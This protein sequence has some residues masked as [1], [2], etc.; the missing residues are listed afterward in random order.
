MNPMSFTEKPAQAIA[1]TS[2]KGGVGKSSTAI[3]LAIALAQSNKRVVLFDGDIGLA[4][5]D[6]LLG[7]RAKRDIS[8]VLA[9]RCSMDE[10]ILN[11]PS[12]IRIVPGG[13]GLSDLADASDAERRSL[14][15][16]ISDLADDTDT[17]IVD[18]PAGIG[19]NTIQFCSAAQEVLVVVCDDPA[20]LTDAYAL[21]KVLHQEAGR[22]RFRVV[23]NMAANESH[24]QM[25][26]KRLVATT[27]RFLDVSVDLAGVIP[28]DEAVLQWARRQKSVMNGDPSTEVAQAFKKLA[29]T[30]DNWPRSTNAHGQLEFFLES[31]IRAQNMGRSMS[32]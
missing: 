7:L 10:V 17:L 5:I 18:T 28:F 6:V 19:P 31:L 9:G 12:G 29:Q 3:A 1:V 4:N 14:I 24:G 16:A 22:D 13:S 32:A 20:S 8:D 26:F 30:T 27:T 25:L 15:Y 21:I 11:G 23:V 2:G